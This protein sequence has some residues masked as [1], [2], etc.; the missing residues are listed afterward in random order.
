M[1]SKFKETILELLNE[2]Q[3]DNN[4]FA[5]LSALKRIH[6]EEV[7][8]LIKAAIKDVYPAMLTEAVKLGGASPEV[9]EQAYLFL[10][11]IV[12]EPEGSMDLLDLQEMGLA[13]WQI[14]AIYE[15][16]LI[17]CISGKD[18]MSFYNP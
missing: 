16:F 7:E 9:L 17:N 15:K 8:R 10:K 12:S 3:T 5:A 2:K 18:R 1:S 11:E 14:Q 4:L 13:D 6:P